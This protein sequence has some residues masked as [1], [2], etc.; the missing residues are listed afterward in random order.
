[1]TK[2]KRDH[3]GQHGRDIGRIYA[4]YHP[5]KEKKKQK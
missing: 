1:M 5:Q 4:L 2:R 3:L